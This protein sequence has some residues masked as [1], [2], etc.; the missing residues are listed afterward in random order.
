MDVGLLEEYAARMHWSGTEVL[1]PEGTPWPAITVFNDGQTQWLADGFHRTR[2]ALTAGLTQFQAVL[3]EGSQEDA[4]LF[5]LGANADHGKRRTKADIR[6]SIET[7]LR[8]SEWSR[9]SDT[10]LAKICKVTDKTIA[11]HRKR[12]EEAQEIPFSL[13]LETAS[14]SYIRRK[15][16]RSLDA[17]GYLMDPAT[18]TG[19]RAEAGDG[20]SVET[21]VFASLGRL[22]ARVLV[23]FPETIRDCD[24]LIES[25]ESAPELV[26]IPISIDTPFAYQAPKHLSALVDVHELIGPRPVYIADQQRHVFVWSRDTNTPTKVTRASELTAGRDSV[27]CGQ[28]LGGWD[29]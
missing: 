7:V 4:I 16:P 29:T 20:A 1:D 6:R 12:M 21:R 22:S 25:I 10:W 8:H 3:K 15:P 24:R 13:E 18:P 27:F 5:S 23:A 2:A 26:A 17:R 9:R 11:R 28:P 19:E 14:T